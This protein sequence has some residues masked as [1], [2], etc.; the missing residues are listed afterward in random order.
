MVWDNHTWLANRSAQWKE[1]GGWGQHQ[2]LASC[3]CELPTAQ[4]GESLR[5]KLF[6][7]SCTAW[8][9]ARRAMRGIR[10]MQRHSTI[11]VIVHV[12]N[13]TTQITQMLYP[14]G[15][16]DWRIYR[17]PLQRLCLHFQTSNFSPTNVILI[18]TSSPE[19]SP[20]VSDLNLTKKSLLRPCLV[21]HN[22]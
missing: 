10:D 12:R 9:L 18:K 7:V 17:A 1:K 11:R 4:S 14:L 22:S 20:N 19:K 6:Q 15:S 16:G 21:K 8:L 5:R 3:S 13:V 2:S